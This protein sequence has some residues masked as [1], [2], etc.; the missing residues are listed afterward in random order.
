MDRAAF[1]AEL[2]FRWTPPSSPGP[3]VQVV[4]PL[5]RHPLSGRE[6]PLDALDASGVPAALTAAVQDVT[7]IPESELQRRYLLL[8][9]RLVDLLR[10]HEA[11][12]GPATNW[13]LLPADTRIVDHTLWNH[14]GVTA[15]LSVALPH[16]ALLVCSVGPVQDFIR[17]ARRTQDLWMGSYMLSYLAWRGIRT[18]ADESGPDAVIYPSLYGQ[19]LVDQWLATDHGLSVR[20]RLEDLSRATLPNKFVALLPARDAKGVAGRVADAVRTAW[21]ELADGVADWLTKQARITTD[22]VWQRIFDAHKQQMP[23]LYWSTYRWPDTSAFAQSKDEADAALDEVQRLLCPPSDWEF[24]H[25]YEVF[26]AT[27][28]KMVNIGTL[29]SC[30]HHLAQRG[31]EARKNLRDFS[32]IEERGEKCTLCGVRV[33]LHN[34][35]QFAR[36]HWSETA[37]RVRNNVKGEFVTI[38]PGGRERL[39]GVCTV[40]RFVQRGFFKDALDLRGG[41][42][43]TSSVAA[44]S[45]KLQVVKKLTMSHGQLVRVL[46]A[47]LNSLDNLELYPVAEST[48]ADML[49]R[50]MDQVGQLPETVQELATLFLRYDGDAFYD[51]TFTVE[52]MKDDYG[53]LT[54][55][56]NQV[57]AARRT[58]G[59]FLG[60][61]RELEIDAPGKYF[62]ILMLDGDEMGK[63]LSGDK[64]PLFSQA[65]G[66]EAVRDLRTNHPAWNAVL[67]AKR[68]LSPALHASMSR[69]LANFALYLVPLVVEQRYCGRVVYAGGDDVLA[70]LPV[71][72]ALSAAR[73]LRAAFSGEATIDSSLQVNPCFRD[74]TV[75]GFLTLKDRPLLTMGPQATASVGISIA[76][77]LSPL[78]AALSAARHAET[79]AKHQYG[80]N[81]LCVHFL[82]RSGEELRVGAR[83][84]YGDTPNN[85]Q[86]TIGVLADVQRRFAENKMSMKFAHSVFDSARILGG[87]PAAQEAELRRLLKRHRGQTLD[88]PEEEQERKD[89]ARELAQLTRSLDQHCPKMDPTF[90]QPQRG[91]VELAKW[92]LLIRFLAQGARD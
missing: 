91:M 22:T 10:Q 50:L 72:Q 13:Y 9:R 25:T 57:D 28:P 80:R 7:S 89:F 11:P 18:I 46:R 1:P 62:A 87:V 16:A 34:D 45:F 92:L 2:Q 77:H 88:S 40:K 41:F 15:A 59:S 44:A 3:K 37:A 24:K 75:S 61:C 56:Q 8:W 39:C 63:W 36:D 38:K 17:T 66:H 55:T 69:A 71:D 20:P 73:E 4:P 14:L 51:E 19:P 74:P 81:A 82:K 79:A 47:H 6:L 49:P 23:E 65:L 84:F 90:D 32:P 64:A 83:W 5:I 70:L 76:H 30:L 52:R 86:D 31:F 43:S 33:A 29:Y 68:V 85:T 78:D 53:L 35:G 42:P 12:G 58:L 48:T 26:C 60:V 27:A 67:D 21:G 54:V